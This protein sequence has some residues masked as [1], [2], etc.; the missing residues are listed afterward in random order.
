[1]SRLNIDHLHKTIE[2]LNKN[3]PIPRGM[4]KT[5]AQFALLIGELHSGDS[6]TTHLVVAPNHSY[7]NW[8]RK[9][10]CNMLDD[11]NCII[12][13]IYESY[14]TIKTVRGQKI[15]FLTMEDV[16]ERTKGIR[17]RTITC[18][19]PDDYF[20]VPTNLY[21]FLDSLLEYTEKEQIPSPL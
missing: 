16:C 5:T 20:G 1:M 7:A 17:L 12:Y 4:G 8:L 21:N 10:F 18:D 3:E 2:K 11:E 6:N 9:Y 19:I 13:K 14:N 15:M